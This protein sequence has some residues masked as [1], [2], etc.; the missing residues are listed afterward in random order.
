M[1]GGTSS[2]DR[3]AFYNSALVRYLDYNDSYLSKGQTCHPSDNLGAV[4]SAVEYING[5]G[6]DLLTSLA[7]AYQVQFN[8]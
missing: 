2:P 4:L 8:I 7:V 3:A 5:N 1:G 6:K